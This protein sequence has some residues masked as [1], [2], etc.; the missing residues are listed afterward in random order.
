MENYDQV[1]WSAKTESKYIEGTELLTVDLNHHTRLFL[2]I[3]ILI[4][5]LTL[6][7]ENFFKLTTV[8]IDVSMRAIILIL[9]KII[10]IKN[11]A[12]LVVKIVYWVNI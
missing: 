10:V 7:L 12:R 5:I 9:I 1:E 6:L 4:I 8:K 2:I 3:F 11:N